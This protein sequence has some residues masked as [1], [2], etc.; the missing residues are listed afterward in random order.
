MLL[1]KW[2]T[3]DLASLRTKT[4]EN[5]PKPRTGPCR[6]QNGTKTSPEVLV[7]EKD[8]AVPL[9]KSILHSPPEKVEEAEKM[10]PERSRSGR[11]ERKF[12]QFNLKDKNIYSVK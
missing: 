11:V 3:L 9:K 1:N 5:N 6:E 10:R 12:F 7:Q 2:R 8:V 4:R